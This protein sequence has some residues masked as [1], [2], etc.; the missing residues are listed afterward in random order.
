MSVFCLFSVCL[1]C[2]FPL[3]QDLNDT[4]ATIP[5]CTFFPRCE[6][7]VDL[8]PLTGRRHQLRIHCSR[9]LGCSILGDDLYHHHHHDHEQQGGAAPSSPAPPR[10]RR[11][12]GLFLQAVELRFRHPC[13]PSATEASAESPTGIPFLFQEGGGE[14]Q[15]GGDGRCCEEYRERRRAR[16]EDGGEAGGALLLLKSNAIVSVEIPEREKFAGVR[17]RALAGATWKADAEQ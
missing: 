2:F 4:C 13:A 5:I 7:T 9:D 1:L 3:S 16:G 10:A 12:R 8:W 6:S 17:N 11:G 15:E 14:D